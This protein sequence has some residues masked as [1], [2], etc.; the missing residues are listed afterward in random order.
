[1]VIKTEATLFQYYWNIILNFEK[2]ISFKVL[3]I[4]SRCLVFHL[5]SY[6][7]Y[8]SFLLLAANLISFINP[9]KY[10]IVKRLYRRPKPESQLCHRNSTFPRN[11]LSSS[12]MKQMKNVRFAHDWVASEW[13]DVHRH[14]CRWKF[15][16]NRS[17]WFWKK[18]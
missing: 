8:R 14:Y 1:M 7:S 18:E 6:P 3:A 10:L 13:E 16:R 5:K 15:Q 9:Y 4:I 17:L 2:N 12:S 11:S